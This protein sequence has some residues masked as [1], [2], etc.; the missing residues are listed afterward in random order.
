MA[1]NNKDRVPARKEEKKEGLL[2]TIVKTSLYAIPIYTI[3]KA[4]KNYLEKDNK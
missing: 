4:F 2:K 1:K 3:G